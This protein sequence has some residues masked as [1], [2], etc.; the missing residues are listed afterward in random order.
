MHGFPEL[1]LDGGPTVA[2]PR[3]EHGADGELEP[4]PGM[5][6]WRRG[7]PTTIDAAGAVGKSSPSSA[8]RL[9]LAKR[10]PEKC[11][12]LSDIRLACRFA[13]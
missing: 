2:P 10:R 12:R 7:H 13:T 6:P 3:A 9:E 11:A 5:Q 4:E 1:G 8:N